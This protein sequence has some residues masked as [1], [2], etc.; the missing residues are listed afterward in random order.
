MA[1][2]TR[3][4]LLAHLDGEL[5]QAEHDRIAGH[6]SG[7]ATCDAAV[8]GLRD[9]AGA[10]GTV[11]RSVD[12]AEP[13]LWSARDEGLPD[14]SPVRGHGTFEAKGDAI[15]F[16]LG[17]LQRAAAAKPSAPI[18]QTTIPPA[19]RWAASIL[20]VTVATASAAIFGRQLLSVPNVAG[21][22]DS[23]TTIEPAVA[24]V[25]ATPVDGALRIRI[26]GT[27]SGSRLFVTYHDRADARLAVEGS[28]ARRFTVQPGRVGLD[29]GD[30]AAIVRLTLP[31]TLRQTVITAN[32]SIVATVTRETIAPAAAAVS[33]IPLDTSDT[34]RME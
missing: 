14:L 13:T 29:L 27:G 18:R 10:F 3:E 30:A 6:V 31:R 7:C 19:L 1:H 15:P 17:R 25:L 20:L 22:A 33:G 2:P 12:A 8:A 24:A 16:P 21:P 34:S 9:S 28:T 26:D 11:L 4:S 5:S 32:G 23:T